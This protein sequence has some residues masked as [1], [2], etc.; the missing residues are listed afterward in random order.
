[1]MNVIGA[2]LAIVVIGLI[3]IFVYRKHKDKMDPTLDKVA[4]KF[5]EVKD[6]I[7]DKLGS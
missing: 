5:D 4:D 3:A 6:K 2:V 1:M 7:S